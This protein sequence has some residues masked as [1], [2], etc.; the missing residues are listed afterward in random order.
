M[1]CV[2]CGKEIE[3]KVIEAFGKDA[4]LCESCQIEWDEI[5]ECMSRGFYDFDKAW[6]AFIEEGGE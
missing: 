4:V 2:R 1:K 3:E 5:L 6:K